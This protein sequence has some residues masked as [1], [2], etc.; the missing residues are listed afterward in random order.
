MDPER[1]MNLQKFDLMFTILYYFI[2][3]GVFFTFYCAYF[4]LIIEFFA[5]ILK[6]LLLRYLEVLAYNLK[7]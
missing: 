1:G 4:R 6:A 5:L 7:I 3:F 2:D